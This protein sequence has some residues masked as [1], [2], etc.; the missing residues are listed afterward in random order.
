MGRHCWSTPLI[1][2][3]LKT[4][5]FVL[6]FPCYTLMIFLIILSAMLLSML[7]VLLST[8]GVIGLLIL[9]K[10]AEMACRY[11]SDSRDSLKW[12]RKLLFDF[13][14]GKS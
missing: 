5:Y 13:N 14:V 1:L 7:V 3:F 11:E 12:G 10:K 9:W 2:V 6:Y 4:P 8:L